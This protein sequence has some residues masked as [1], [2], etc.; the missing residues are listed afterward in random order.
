MCAYCAAQ[1][2]NREKRQLLCSLCSLCCY[3]WEPILFMDDVPYV[4]VT[5]KHQQLRL[6]A[7]GATRWT[8]AA[9]NRTRPIT[10]T[11]KKIMIYCRYW[12]IL[13][14]TRHSVVALLVPICNIYFALLKVQKMIEILLLLLLAYILGEIVIFFLFCFPIMAWRH[15]LGSCRI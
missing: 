12:E 3:C 7:T 10:Q 9:A 11:R 1:R 8:P 2:N 13:K 15:E 4:V 5:D 14:Y 6:T